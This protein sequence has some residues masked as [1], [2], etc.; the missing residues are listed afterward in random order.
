M[1]TLWT[2]DPRTVATYDTE[3]A[4]RHDH[5]FYLALAAE[6]RARTVV[7]VGCGTGVFVTDLAQRGFRA[8]GVDPSAQMLEVARTREGG[9][10]ATWIHGTAADL[11]A[12]TADLVV[13]MG[14]VAQ[15]FLDED[16]WQ[17][18][19]SHV[20]RALRAG[21]HLAFESRQPDRGWPSRWTRERTETTF[22]HPDGGTFTSWVEVTEVVGTSDSFTETHVGHTDLPDGTHLA[23]AETLRFRSE[24]EIR[25]GLRAA[26]FAVENL[27]GDWDRSPVTTGSDELIVL[28]RRD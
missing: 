19:L 28:A 13:M 20:H 6:L 21:A 12:G 3:C 10:L 17:H 2:E 8:I 4:G 18:A 9:D 27:W 7:D 15:Y 24:E 26:G 25:A 11:P 1:S 5:D 14:H 22:E 16:A 23:H